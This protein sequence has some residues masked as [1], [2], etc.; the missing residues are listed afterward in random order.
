M[1]AAVRSVLVAVS[2]LLLGAATA[3]AQA[4]AGDPDAYASCP[5]AGDAMFVEVSRASCD[6]ARAVAVAI[7]AAPPSGLQTA[8]MAA[9]WTPLRVIA[10]DLQTAYDIYATR[11]TATVRIRRRGDTPDIDGWMAGRE[12]VFSTRT[13]VVGGSAPNGSAL[14]TS[15]F[16]VRL[17]THLGGL[18]AAHCAGLTKAGT[19]RR[20]ST[21]LRRAPLPWIPLGGVRRNLQRRSRSIDAL[22]LPIPSGPGRIASNVVERFAFQPP[23]FVRGTARPLLGRRVCFSGVTSGP[24]NCGKIVHPFPGV[25]RLSCTTITAREGDSGSP[26]YT[27]PAADGTVRAIGIANIVYSIFQFMCFEPIGPVLGALDAT[28]VNAGG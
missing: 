18:S 4:D 14:C 11:G 2:S 13:L 23:L 21:A 6:D 8:L 26:V 24:N 15:A 22:V 5:T 19:T 12:L 25:G 7:T 20:R 27:P 10:L 17:G 9:G 3:H 16:L 28:L 1:H